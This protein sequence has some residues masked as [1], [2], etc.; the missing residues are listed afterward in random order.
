MLDVAIKRVTSLGNTST[1]L[2]LVPIEPT[3]CSVTLRPVAL[4]KLVSVLLLLMAPRALTTTARAASSWPRPTSSAPTKISPDTAW[5]IEPL[6]MTMS[7][8]P[9]VSADKRPM[10][11]MLPRACRLPVGEYRSMSRPE[12]MFLTLRPVSAPCKYTEKPVGVEALT[13]PDALALTTKGLAKVPTDPLSAVSDASPAS[14]E[15]VRSVP[16]ASMMA[17]CAVK[18]TKPGEYTSAIR[19]SPVWVI[20]MPSCARATKVALLGVPPPVSVMVTGLRLVPMLPVAASKMAL[21]P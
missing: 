2:V 12:L 14:K 10:A 1:A 7:P 13:P 4:T 16:R 15:R 17:F 9:S 8:V 21:W 20:Q 3:A 18:P 6:S 5:N 19:M 11:L